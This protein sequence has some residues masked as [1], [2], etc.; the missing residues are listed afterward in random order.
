MLANGLEPPFE[1]RSFDTVLTPWFIDVASPDVRDLIGAIHRVLRVGGRWV[2]FGPLLYGKKVPL[3]C[4][5][6]EQE[7]LELTTMAG[8]EVLSHQSSELPYTY[9]P[10]NGR[11]KIERTLSFSARKL[12]TVNTANTAPTVNNAHHY[13]SAK[14]AAPTVPWLILPHLPV[15]VAPS[16]EVSDEFAS[17]AWSEVDGAR[18]IAEIARRVARCPA[19]QSLNRS[20]LQDA[21][22]E[23]F[24]AQHPD[25]FKPTL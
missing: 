1:A 23:L 14:S 20:Q 8:F 2:N 17:A 9:S 24:A 7:L 13:A 21:L 12:P 19:A 5:F 22:R 10:L 4:R 16:P 15:P 25:V 3:G 6:T 11:G 18:G